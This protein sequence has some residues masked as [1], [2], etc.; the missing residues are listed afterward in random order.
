MNKTWATLLAAVLPPVI[1]GVF[2]LLLDAK[3]QAVYDLR[4]EVAAL[5]AANAELAGRVGEGQ[6]AKPRR[7]A[8]QSLAGET[9]KAAAEAESVAVS[10]TPAKPRRTWLRSKFGAKR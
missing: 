1:A 3:Q 4:Y 10:T 6:V 9:V 2:G 5:K 8:P 7:P